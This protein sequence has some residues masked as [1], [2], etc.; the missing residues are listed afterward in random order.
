MKM[1]EKLAACIEKLGGQSCILC[2]V[3]NDS[4]A[5]FVNTVL[6]CITANFNT[7]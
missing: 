4:V 1:G 2:A 6:A 5:K 3:A 7:L